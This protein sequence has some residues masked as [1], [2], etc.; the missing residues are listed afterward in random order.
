MKATDKLDKAIK[1]LDE[2]IYVDLSEWQRAN[3]LKM[4]SGYGMWWFKIGNEKKSFSGKYSEAK[5]MAMKYAKEKG[6]TTIG[7]LP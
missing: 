5:A 2:F 4:P 1:T 7:V 6:V 3:G